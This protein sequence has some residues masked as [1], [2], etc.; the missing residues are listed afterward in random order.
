MAT[1]VGAPPIGYDVVIVQGEAQ[2]RLTRR[3]AQYVASQLLQVAP[4]QEPEG[5]E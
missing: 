1:P 4:I 3:Q 2:I 5:E